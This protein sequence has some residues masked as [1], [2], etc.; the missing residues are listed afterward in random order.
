MVI[1]RATGNFARYT[2]AWN[3]FG[4]LPCGVFCKANDKPF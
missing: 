2:W 4:M 3:G 1:L